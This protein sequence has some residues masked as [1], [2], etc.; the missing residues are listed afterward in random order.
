MH[1]KQRSQV[2]LTCLVDLGTGSGSES[3]AVFW[4]LDGEALDW[5]GQTGPGRGVR[6]TERRGRQLISTLIIEKADIHHAGK[7]TCAPSYAKP[8]TVTL[9]VIDGKIFIILNNLYLSGN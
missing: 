3:A 1:V 5:L 7:F 2:K 6:V 9:H 8:D 4:Y